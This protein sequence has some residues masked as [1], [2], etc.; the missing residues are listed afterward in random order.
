MLSSVKA[1]GFSVM[2]SAVKSE[3]FF[4]G[5]GSSFTFVLNVPFII[6]N[7]SF[8]LLERCHFPSL[9]LKNFLSVLPI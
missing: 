7:C 3:L 5:G 1:F 8:L 6:Y 9:A 2:S 4:E